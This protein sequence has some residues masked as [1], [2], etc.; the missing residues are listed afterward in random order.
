MFFAVSYSMGNT[1]KVCM[2]V[3]KNSTTFPGIFP[4]K[5]EGA[6]RLLE[7]EVLSTIYM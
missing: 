3:T 4:W 6:T 7:T 5:M 1:N 2:Y